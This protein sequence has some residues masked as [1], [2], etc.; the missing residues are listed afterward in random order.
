MDPFGIELES[1]PGVTKTHELGGLV[2]SSL[3]FL[4]DHPTVGN[5]DSG[6]FCLKDNEA[7]LNLHEPTS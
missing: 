7:D 3:D 2:A 1:G 6:L 4:E 5:S